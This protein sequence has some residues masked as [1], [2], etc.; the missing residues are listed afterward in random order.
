MSE[1]KQ[2]ENMDAPRDV[3]PKLCVNM[4]G[5][6]GS[7][8]TANMCS[9]CYKE[10]AVA[11][12]D[13]HEMPMDVSSPKG[14][15][16]SNYFPGSASDA[17]SPTSASDDHQLTALTPLQQ[18]SDDLSC[19]SDSDTPGTPDGKKPRRELQAKKE[20]CWS[21]NKKVGLLGHE[22][23][24]GYIFCSVHRYA[25]DHKCDYDFKENGRKYLTEQNPIVS[26]PKV[27]KI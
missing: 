21:C 26:A 13:K 18:E 3:E 1:N 12:K 17:P 7:S 14:S 23:R 11:Q 25:E 15:G 24:C 22:C 19:S 5:F 16:G 8:V 20:R 9:K 6:F 27:P 2:M 10:A 4:C